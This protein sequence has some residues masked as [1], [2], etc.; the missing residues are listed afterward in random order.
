M[1]VIDGA[2]DLG[3]VEAS[4]ILGENSLAFEVEVQFAPVDVFRD[5]AKAIR[6]GERVT[7]RQQEGMIYSLKRN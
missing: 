7:K 2:D 3:S 1:K 6:S 4:S 5:Q